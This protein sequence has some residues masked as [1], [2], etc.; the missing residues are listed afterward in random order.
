MGEV[1]WSAIE[2]IGG[3][4]IKKGFGFDCPKGV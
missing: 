2:L 4:K 3:I 1:Q